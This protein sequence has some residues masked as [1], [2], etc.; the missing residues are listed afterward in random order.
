VSTP[1][2]DADSEW[3]PGRRAVLVIFGAIVLVLLLAGYVANAY[4]AETRERL[5]P[6]HSATAR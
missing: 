6:Q 1:G 2:R 4:R 5:A 3:T